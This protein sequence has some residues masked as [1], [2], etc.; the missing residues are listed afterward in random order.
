MAST[1]QIHIYED[2]SAHDITNFLLEPSVPAAHGRSPLK[3]SQSRTTPTKARC[4]PLK[5]VLLPPPE[6]VRLYNLSP[7][8]GPLM[9]TY[10]GAIQPVPDTAVFG[11]LPP[12]CHFDQENLHPSQHSD[13]CA[14]FP[15]PGY[16]HATSNSNPTTANAAPRQ[17]RKSQSTGRESSITPHLPEPEDLPTPEDC[18]GKPNYSYAALI[19]MSILRAP[20]RR[21]SL[22]QIYKWISDTFSFYR[23]SSDSGWQNSIRHNLSINKAFCKQDRPKDDPG[24]GRFWTIKPGMEAQFL[25]E[26]PSRRP[27]SAGGPTMKTFSQPLN[28]PSPIAWSTPATKALRSAQQAP[29]V[30]EQPSSDGTIPASDVVSPGQFHDE[31]PVMPP[32]A[33][34]LLSSSPSP[35]IGSSPPLTLHIE[36]GEASPS[37][38]SDFLPAA[39]PPRTKKR[40]STAMD[41]SGYFSSLES[42]VI[43]CSAGIEADRPR[44]K[45]GR[46]EEEI[47][48]IRSSSH[49]LSPTKGRSIVKPFT[50][51]VASSSP[52]PEFETSLMPPPPP[53]L[54]PGVALPQPPQVPASISPLTHLR[55]HRH[56]VSELT[57]LPSDFIDALKDEAVPSPMFELDDDGY[58]NLGPHGES[59]FGIDIFADS[60]PEFCSRSIS[61]S[62][63]KGSARRSRLARPLKTSGVLT[64]MSSSRLNRTIMTPF[65]PVPDLE[66]PIRKNSVAKYLVD[67]EN[68]CSPVKG[69]FFGS[70]LFD[71]DDIEEDELGGFDLTQGFPGIGRIQN[72]TTKVKKT[73]RPLLG[74]RSHTSRF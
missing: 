56:R 7:T 46:A 62:P 12:F 6:E 39:A 15:D 32:P 72:A 5:N 14:A 68:R 21:L 69:D 44:L 50:P 31:A 11:E 63:E 4:G 58:Y 42:S 28:E 10:H 70:R 64:A 23:V 54:T 35:A 13:N 60:A 53:P 33:S 48:R 26:K 55:N 24:K 43:K 27:P 66:S 17:R 61:A 65:L 71:D 37:L 19:G 49:D 59:H 25:K 74:A 73:T 22:A 41:D 34:R 2:P 67:Q 1:R 3:S 51:Q 30:S 18:L 16:V 45:R 20:N 40:K 57:E 38:A 47:A 29:A 8:K 9:D 52:L 36:F